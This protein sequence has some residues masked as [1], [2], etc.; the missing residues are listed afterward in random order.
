MDALHKGMM[1][2][3]LMAIVDNTKLHSV[4]YFKGGTCAVLCGWLDRFSVDL[5]FDLSRGAS[6]K[7]VRSLLTKIMQDHEFTITQQAKNELFFVLK[8]EA[9]V[10]KR[11]TM[12]VSVIDT[13]V[14]ANRYEPQYLAAIDRYALCQTKETMV[15]N[16]LVALTDRFKRYHTIAGRDIYDIWYFLRQGFGFD[17]RIIIERTGKSAKLY[18]QELRD[19][20]TKHVTEP[21][22]TQ[23]LNFLL[24]QERFRAIQKTLK[25]EVLILLDEV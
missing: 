25:R 7:E 16:K 24:P 15:A 8:Y 2:R 20:I 14:R 17:E 22:I 12:K 3:L 13:F 6:K 4:L 18:I 1:Y 23:D 5:D 9:P 19:F 21:V 11:N 10:G